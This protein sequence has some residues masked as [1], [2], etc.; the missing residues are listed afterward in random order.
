MW[1]F[2]PVLLLLNGALSIQQPAS[3]GSS[4]AANLEK[5]GQLKSALSDGYC[6]ILDSNIGTSR[7]SMANA[8]K[9]MRSCLR[10]RIFG[11][12]SHERKCNRFRRSGFV[13]DRA[14]DIE[15]LK[16]PEHYAARVCTNAGSMK[17]RTSMRENS[18]QL[19]ERL[20][21]C[22]SAR[23]SYPVSSVGRIG[24]TKNFTKKDCQERPNFKR[25]HTNHSD[26][27]LMNLRCGKAQRIARNSLLSN[28]K[29][30]ISHGVKNTCVKHVQIQM[31]FGY[32]SNWMRLS[33][34]NHKNQFRVT[35]IAWDSIWDGS[36]TIPLSQSSMSQPDNVFISSVY[37]CIRHI[38]QWLF[39]AATL[40][41]GTTMRLSLWTLRAA[42]RAA[43]R[44]SIRISSS[45]ERA[46]KICT[47]RASIGARLIKSQSLK[48]LLSPYKNSGSKS[49]LN[50]LCCWKSCEFMRR[51]TS[52]GFGVS[53]HQ[54]ECMTTACKASLWRFG[55]H[56][57]LAIADAP[58]DLSMCC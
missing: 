4:P 40:H 52:Q 8:S 31:L 47:T 2:A 57:A 37:R 55:E 58:V 1:L 36:A 53:R 46:S 42:A 50:F 45:T 30:R 29:L 34:A 56:G 21:E 33:E 17:S 6:A 27:A 12:I 38:R 22:D 39:T 7:R 41:P 9:S 23:Q 14:L 48:K 15:V 44:Q 25:T 28:H 11:A 5:R 10:G 24:I 18:G 51:N 13:M 19:R 26:F 54:I 49:P 32:L 3:W 20:P 16:S 43:K 35:C